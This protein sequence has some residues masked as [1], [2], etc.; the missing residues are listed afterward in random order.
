MPLEIPTS[1]RFIQAGY[2]PHEERTP[3]TATAPD[4]VQET[5]PVEP[6][7]EYRIEIACGRNRRSHLLNL[8]SHGR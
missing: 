5:L 2:A 6:K 4:P 7:L 3:T 8:K 1:K